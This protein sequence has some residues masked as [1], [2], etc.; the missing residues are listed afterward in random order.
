MSLTLQPV[1][2]NAQPLTFSFD[3]SLSGT[4]HDRQ[5]ALSVV[6]L[7]F[8]CEQGVRREFRPLCFHAVEVRTVA[9]VDFDD[10]AFVNEEG[11]T[12]FH[13][14]FEFSGTGQFL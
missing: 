4:Q 11:H 7:N 13:A 12:H 2:R 1:S 3:V 6:L 5:L 14:G 10:F 9:S 8:P